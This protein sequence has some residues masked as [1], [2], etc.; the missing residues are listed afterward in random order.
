M[1]HILWYEKPASDWKNGLPVGTGRLAGMVLGGI[2]T[3]RIALNHEWLCLGQHSNRINQDR[4][5]F[6]PQVRKLLR[7]EKYKDATEL[8]NIA[9]GGNGGVSLTPSEEDPF[10]P[11]GDFCFS[12][13]HKNVTNYRR[14]LDM[15]KAHVMITYDADGS[16]VT[17]TVIG[18]LIHDLIVVRLS[19][20]DH[21]L[22][23][24]FWLQRK[25]D[26]RCDIT[27]ETGAATI[28]MHGH[29][30]HGMSFC[31]KADFKINSGTITQLDDNRLS[32]KDAKEILI[33]I[34]IGTDAK[35]ILPL[36][37]C[38]R[39]TLPVKN[40]RRLYQD[41]IEEH[42][43]S[44]GR[45]HLSIPEQEPSL[46][47]NQR[48][49]RFQSG[50]EDATL[51]VLFF[52]YGR[53][54]LTASSANGELP[55]NLQ[56]KWS[57]ELVPAWDCDYHYE[58]NLQMN[59][60]PIENGYLQ[61]YFEPFIVHMEKMVPYGRDAAKKLYGCDGIWFPLSSDIWGM[62]TPE[63]YGWSVWVGVSAWIAQHLWWHYEY[64]QDLLYLSQRAY[65]FMKEVATF[66]E[67]FLEK[68]EDGI[69]QIMPSQSP[70]NRFEGTGDLPV[71]ICTSSTID[72]LLVMDLFEH[73][74]QAAKLLKTD[75]DKLELWQDILDHL[76]NI[77]V[78]SKGQ[79]LEW[80]QEFK[81]VEPNHR[82]M[83]HLFG[84]FPGEEINEFRTPDLF[85]AARISLDQRIS[86]GGGYTGWSRA[87]TACLY[88][89]FG[90]GDIAYQHLHALI[91]DYATESLLALHP[92][93]IFQIDGNLGGTAAI[94]EM[95][96]QSYYEEM[97][98]LPALPS[99]WPDGKITGIRGRGGFTIDMEWKNGQLT[100][101][102][103]LSTVNHL[104][105]IISRGRTYVIRDSWGNMVDY[106]MEDYYIYF[107]ASEN[108]MYFVHVLPTNL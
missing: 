99:C 9:W 69:Y 11:A 92:P 34:N 56:G 38:R 67:N 63:T 88:A 27:N 29:F 77:K 91:S 105:K 40:W 66:Y 14:E 26:P 64:G 71:S 84:V 87:W 65:P 60:W 83:S 68:D 53:Y 90:E 74:L 16:H 94:L 52:N 95:L 78:G 30:H 18:D 43:A 89:R 39:N 81:E 2:D 28:I 104:C 61:E 42:E 45:L 101:A 85:K 72:V 70:E 75:L 1:N 108:R 55:A 76:P 31:V 20:P 8:S 82:H 15:E 47:T 4:S 58:V 35:G 13:N 25:E 41:N 44:Y 59:Y 107:H 17:R 106:Q 98:F 86:A 6:L 93:G 7:E 46:P 50:M 51:P 100:T 96:F 57:E 102:R 62:A 33:F 12:L 103:I 21:P 49:E 23:G 24:T 37:E 32:I 36:E 10:Q 22:E 48:I 3:E 80:N 73:I 5:A 54:L 19:C 97:D 79:L